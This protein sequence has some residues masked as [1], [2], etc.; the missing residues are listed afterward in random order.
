[1]PSRFID[2]VQKP[3]L[4]R[5]AKNGHKNDVDFSS[6]LSKYSVPI[7]VL[8]VLLGATAFYFIEID[9]LKH[10]VDALY[11]II[12]TLTTVGYGD[13]VPMSDGGKMFIVVYIFI[14]LSFIAACFGLLAAKV[15][16][17]VEKT[18][19][20]DERTMHHRIGEIFMP[21]L[22]VTINMLCAALVIRFNEDV[23]WVTAIYWAMVSLSSVGYGDPLI[24]KESTRTF[25]VFFLLWGVTSFAWA[26]GRI[27]AVFTEIEEDLQLL[28]FVQYGLT[29]KM[30]REMDHNNSG[31]VSR[32]EFVLQMLVKLNRVCRSDIDEIVRMFEKFDADGSGVLTEEDIDESIEHNR[33]ATSLQ[34]SKNDDKSA[35]KAETGYVK[36][37]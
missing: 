29:R 5:R 9:H 11:F 4:N 37:A 32:E 35:Y 12:L 14:G 21:M 2:A 8:Y 20:L 13:I 36:T 19:K 28:R 24:V 34:T 7:I 22:V 31:A 15:A 10:W 23:D 18:I 6:F 33:K 3:L 30:I 1:M 27:A 25:L 26:L 17:K 16:S